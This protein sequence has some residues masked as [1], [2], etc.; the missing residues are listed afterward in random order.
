M[1][2]ASAIFAVVILMITCHQE[3]NAYA[4][5]YTHVAAGRCQSDTMNAFHFIRPVRYSGSLPLLIILDSGGDGLL[6]VRK[7]EPAVSGFSC[8]VVGSDQV[9]NNFQGYI[10]TIDNL[11]REF[12]MRYSVSRIYLAGFSGGA[13][14]AYEYA[15]LHSVQGVIMCGAGPSGYTYKELPCPVFMI[16]GTTDFNFSET[17]YNPLKR[18]GQLN[19]VSGYFRGIHEWPPADMLNQ[20]LLF[21]MGKSVPGGTDLLRLK[22]VQLSSKADSLLAKKETFFALKAIELALAFDAKNTTA[23]KQW[24]EFENNPVYQ[25]DIAGLESD[26]ALETRINQAYAQASMTKDSTWWFNELE[27][28]IRLN[29]ITTWEC[30]K[31]HFMR[32]KAF[33]GILFYSRLNTLIHSQ[34]DNGQIIHILAAYR[35]ANPKIRMYIM[36]MPCFT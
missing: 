7:M 6:A 8:L 13:R 11:I 12:S 31:D 9:R 23:K 29:W 5:D 30:K 16:A 3:K 27:T 22:S 4:V 1:N 33:L 35:K 34:P 20:G 17:Y 36:I 28:V 24:E 18:S 10:Q 15:R 21:L 2:R 26:L 19:L 32:I 14:M 25:A